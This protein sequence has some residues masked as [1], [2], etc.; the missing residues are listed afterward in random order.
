MIFDNILGELKI[1]LSFKRIDN[2]NPRIL[3]NIF[4][5]ERLSE[6]F[7]GERILILR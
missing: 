3:Q 1:E 7:H 6:K 5:H 2:K 4:A